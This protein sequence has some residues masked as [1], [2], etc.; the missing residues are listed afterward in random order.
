VRRRHVSVGALVLVGV[1]VAVAVA[2]LVLQ[3]AESWGEQLDPADSPVVPATASPPGGDWRVAGELSEDESIR[4]GH[5]LRVDD[6]SVS[7]KSLDGETFW[8]YSRDEAWVVSHAS[9]GELE[10]LYFDDDVVVG[11]DTRTG[12]PL[13]H[14]RLETPLAD[15]FDDDQRFILGIGYSVDA[16]VVVTLTKPDRP[17]ARDVADGEVL[18]EARDVADGEVRWS[19]PLPCPDPEDLVV[20]LPDSAFGL[21]GCDGQHVLVALSL[22]DGTELWRKTT[23]FGPLLAPAADAL[24]PQGTAQYGHRVEV[25]DPRTGRTHWSRDVDTPQSHD[26]FWVVASSTSVVGVIEPSDTTQPIQ[27]VAWDLASGD[28]RWRVELVSTDRDNV[29]IA[30]ADGFVYAVVTDQQ[31]R[32]T[33]VTLDETTGETLASRSLDYHG[34]DVDVSVLGPYVVVG[35]LVLTSAP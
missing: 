29:S 2:V 8:R 17:E 6:G 20:P 28:E 16:G 9:V 18:L 11:L 22:D 3:R 24:I 15:R 34:G 19:I 21:F 7:L 10:V 26:M 23:D 32:N 12:R 33:L 14:Q 27:V 25:M 4:L 1:A 31:L 35:D 30:A 5:V 13:W